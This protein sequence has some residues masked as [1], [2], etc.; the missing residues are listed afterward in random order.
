MPVTVA[1]PAGLTIGYPRLSPDELTLYF[2]GSMSGGD[3]DLYSAVRGSLHDGF[4]E[5]QPLT[6]VNS[7]S[8]DQDPMVSSDGLTLWF[9]TTRDANQGAHIYVATRASTLAA[10]GGAAPAVTVNAAD[11]T[12]S[13][14]QPFATADNAEMWFASTRTPTQ[15]SR[16]IW[17]ATRTAG[18]LAAPAADTAL[19]STGF[20]GVPTLSADRLTIFFNSNRMDTGVK[21]GFDIWIAH[22][23]TASGAFGAPGLVAEVNTAGNDIPGWISSDNCRLYL[24]NDSSS[25]SQIFVATRQP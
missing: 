24:R 1:A 23:M 14:S 2:A 3:F 6:A 12:V 22:R 15:G 18:G 11:T 4:G 13:D 10:F 21:G 17:H 9:S 20:D 25:T 5:P 8:N 7:T 19:D 16:D